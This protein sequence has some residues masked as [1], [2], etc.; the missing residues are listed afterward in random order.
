MPGRFDPHEVQVADGHQT[1][2]EADEGEHEEGLQGAED[3][4]LVGDDDQEV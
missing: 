3:H 2:G 4:R 1:N